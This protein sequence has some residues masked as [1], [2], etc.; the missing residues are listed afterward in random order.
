VHERAFAALARSDAGANP[1][2]AS[3]TVGK[4]V[5]ALSRR[6]RL[7]PYTRHIVFRMSDYVHYSQ[8]HQPGDTACRM[9]RYTVTAPA[10]P[11]RPGRQVTGRPIA[12]PARRKRE[13]LRH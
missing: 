13:D 12:Y 4:E 9:Y 11:G 5:A 8:N 3:C 2:D 1:T 7:A 10:D 6:V